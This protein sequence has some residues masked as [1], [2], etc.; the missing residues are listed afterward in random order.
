LY[1]SHGKRSAQ[2]NTGSSIIGDSVEA[3]YHTV[4][5][6]WVCRHNH[7]VGV[8]AAEEGCYEVE[9]GRIDQKH[10]LAGQTHVLQVSSDGAGPLFQLG[11]RHDGLIE[12]I[13]K[14][15]N[16]CRLIRILLSLAAERTDQIVGKLMQTDMR[17][18]VN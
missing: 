1:L 2:G 3:I 4:A 12:L 6:R 17:F 7:T 14:Q 8:Q 5:M 15:M 11:V 18:S 10:S 16:K 9:A 13:I